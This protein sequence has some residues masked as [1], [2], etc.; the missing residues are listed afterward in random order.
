MPDSLAPLGQLED[1]RN[2]KSGSTITT[3]S[4]H[5][6]HW[7]LHISTNVN[8]RYIR[9]API[10]SQYFFSLSNSRLVSF[11]VHLYLPFLSILPYLRNCAT[12]QTVSSF[13]FKLF[14]NYPFRSI[15]AIICI[16]FF[17][18]ELTLSTIFFSSILLSN[19]FGSTTTI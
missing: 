12:T 18:F 8:T 1:P 11:F 2:A 3:P 17:S 13:R 14:G 19:Y 6:R 4:L 16:E 7:N 5:L 9:L 15:L 10:F